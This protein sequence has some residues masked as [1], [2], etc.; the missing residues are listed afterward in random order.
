V[1]PRRISITFFYLFKLIE[2]SHDKYTY[3]K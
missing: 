1:P 3:L 2:K